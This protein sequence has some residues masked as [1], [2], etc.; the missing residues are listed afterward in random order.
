MITAQPSST[1]E[2][3]RGKDAVT[4]T[5]TDAS[6]QEKEIGHMGQLSRLPMAEG[7]STVS[8][9]PL[10]QAVCLEPIQ[11]NMRELKKIKSMVQFSFVRCFTI[12]IIILPWKRSEK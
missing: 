12:G 6:G 9:M 11:Q 2:G 7:V 8:R 4:E 3:G 1:P 5:E 10:M